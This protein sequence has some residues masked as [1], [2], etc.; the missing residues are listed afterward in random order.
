M[1]TVRDV[2]LV[3]VI[4][5]TFATLFF[6][7][8]FT[9]TT[10]TNRMMAISAINQSSSTVTAL[11]GVQT[12][13]NRLDYV[14]FGIFVGLTLAII[15]S[16]WFIGG[17]PIFMFIYFIVLAIGVAFST[18]LSNTWETI[19]TVG[20]F[21]STVNSFPITNHILLSLPIYV[22][23]IG[24]IGIV[25]MFAKPFFQQNAGYGGY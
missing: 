25:V 8:N 4:L 14:L 13:V 19:S 23:V 18:I 9:A 5:F 12:T 24:F 7:V 15:I 3:G 21:G 10:I 17:H 1:A 20:A 22:T 6:V 16:G 2:I 11:Q